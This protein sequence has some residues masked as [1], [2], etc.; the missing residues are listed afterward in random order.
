MKNSIYRLLFLILLLGCLF[1]ENVV[2]QSKYQYCL[3]VKQSFYSWGSCS[4]DPD[5]DYAEVTVKSSGDLY[6]KIDNNRIDLIIPLALELKGTSYYKSISNIVDSNNSNISVIKVH[7]NASDITNDHDLYYE[8][9]GSELH[10]GA[11]SISA[12]A[13]D[14]CNNYISNNRE[15]YTMTTTVYLD[16]PIN[17]F[18]YSGKNSYCLDTDILTL[19]TDDFF[20]NSFYMKGNNTFKLPYLEVAIDDS[21]KEEDAD[22]IEIKDVIIKPSTLI[23]LSYQRIAGEKSAN[24]RFFS[25]MGKRLKF[26][27]VK[28][29]LNG[30]RTYG[31]IAAGIIFYPK[32]PSFTIT[33]TRRTGCGDSKVIVKVRLDNDINDA[34][35]FN[36]DPDV[37]RWVVREKVAGTSGLGTGFY[38]CKPSGYNI[39]NNEFILELSNQEGVTV[40]PFSVSNVE[41]IQFEMQLQD[42]KNTSQYYCVKPFTI[43]PKPTPITITQNH[44]EWLV[45]NVIYDVPDRNNI[46]ANLNIQDNYILASERQPYRIVEKGGIEVLATVDNLNKSF[47]SLTPNEKHDDTVAFNLYFAEEVKKAKN[48]YLDY[49]K[50]KYK[51]WFD[52][53]KTLTIY[54]PS[55]EYYF[56]VYDYHTHGHTHTCEHAHYHTHTCVCIPEPT[57]IVSRNLES[58]KKIES[59]LEVRPIDCNN[60]VCSDHGVD[61][62]PENMCVSGHQHY[63]DSNPDFIEHDDDLHTHSGYHTHIHTHIGSH[64]HGENRFYD[65]TVIRKSTGVIL[66][67][68]YSVSKSLNSYYST[69]EFDNPAS[70]LFEPTSNAAEISD[71][72]VP[73]NNVD[74]NVEALA[75]FVD[76]SEIFNA[77][78]SKRLSTTGLNAEYILVK[79]GVETKVPIWNENDIMTNVYPAKGIAQP[80]YEEF[81]AFCFKKWLDNKYGYKLYNGVI[82]DTDQDFVLIDKDSC[83]YEFSTHV[84]VPPA[85]DFGKEIV[86]RPDNAC[87]RNGVVKV[88]YNGGG[89]PPYEY[90]GSY[91]RKA[92]DYILVSNLGY[93]ENI[94]RFNDGSI[95]GLNLVLSIEDSGTGII[96]VNRTPNTCPTP[97]GT[98]SVKTGMIPN[99]KTFRLKLRGSSDPAIAQIISND[100]FTF[101]DLKNGIYD[102]EV[103][104]GNNCVFRESNIVV[105]S[106]VFNIEKIT[107]TDATT[108]D[109]AGSVRIEFDNWDSN[110]NWVAPTPIGFDP[111]PS[112]ANVNYNGIIPNS[113]NITATHV[114]ESGKACNVSGQFIIR[115]P[116]FESEVVVEETNEGLFAKARLKSF[117]NFKLESKLQLY[118]DGSVVKVYDYFQ[119]LSSII[120]SN[121]DYKIVLKDGTDEAELCSFTY[122]LTGINNGYEVSPPRCPG[123]NGVIKLMPS[124]GIDG[125]NLLVSTDGSL[126]SKT[127]TYYPKSGGFEYY[128]KSEKTYD[129]Y[130]FG[131]LNKVRLS[132]IKKFAVDI[133]I[134]EK[135]NAGISAINVTCSGKNDGEIS[136]TKL[137]GGSGQYKFKVDDGLWNNATYTVT[138]LLPGLHK[139]YLKDS[140]NN[141]DSVYI[142][143]VTIKEPSPLVIERLDVVQPTCEFNNGSISAEIKGGNG[144]YKYIWLYNGDEFS[145]NDILTNDTIYDLGNTLRYGSYKLKIEDVYKCELEQDVNLVQY[146]NPSILSAKPVLVRC[147]GESNGE[148][149]V[150]STGGSYLIKEFYINEI[151]KAISDTIKSTAENFQNLKKGIYFITAVDVLGCYSNASDSYRIDITQPDT[152]VYLKLGQVQPVLNKGTRTGGIQATVFGG[153]DRLKEI[154]ITNSD[155]TW[156][157]T[158]Q[159]IEG[160]SFILDHLNAGKYS[161]L[162]TDSKGCSDTLN[163]IT[164]EEPQFP[165]NFKDV[166]VKNARCKAQTGSIEVQAEGGWGDYIFSGPSYGENF[167][168]GNRFENLYAGNYVITVK[169]KL[170]AT[171]SDTIAIYE[172]KDSLRSWVSGHVFPTCSNNG[173]IKLAFKGGTAPY[174]VFD[175]TNRF[176][177]SPVF[178][179]EFTVKG[180]NAN[181]YFM[182]ITDGNGCLYDLHT[183]LS[184]AQMLDVSF[185]DPVYPTSNS[186]TNGMICAVAKGGVNPL[187]YKWKQRFGSMYSETSSSLK[188][189]PS[190]HYEL[191]VAEKGGCSVTRTYYLPSIGDYPFAVAKIE[192]ETSFNKKNGYCKLTSQFKNWKEFEFITPTVIAHFNSGESNEQFSCVGD[193][194]LLKNLAGGTYFVSG[195]ADDTIKVYAEFT[196][197]PYIPFVLK[198]PVVENVKKIGDSNGR[199]SLTV[200][201]GGGGNTFEWKRTSAP[202]SDTLTAQNSPYGS[203]LSDIPAGSYEVTVIDRF[204]NIITQNVDVKE[205][206]MP[207]SVSIADHKDITCKTYNNGYVI[208]K[209]TGGW[210]GYQFKD[211][212]DVNYSNANQYVNLDP[213]NHKFYIIDKLGV[214]ES[215]A[216]S[217]TEPDYLNST[218]AFI[219]SV[220]CKGESTG[221]VKFHVTGGTPPYKFAYASNQNFW[222]NDTVARNV[223]YGE[224][225]YI[226]KDDNN[227]LT[228]NVIP[229]VKM[230]EPES[231]LFSK[232]DVTHTTCNIDNGKIEV[233]LKGGSKPYRYEWLN[234][235]NQNVGTASL[236]SQLSRNGFYKLNVYDRHDCYQG[237]DTII[238]P[239]SNPVVT[240]IDTTPVLCYGGSNGSALIKSVKAGDPYAPYTFEWSNGDSDTISKGY[241][242]GIYSVIVT[243]TNKCST[244]SYFEITQ[245][246]SLRISITD[247]KNAHCFD[248]ND[249]FL[250]AQGFGG[251]GTYTYQWSNGAVTNRIDKLYRGDYTLTLK[252]AN[253]CQ[254]IET[255]SVIEPDKLEVDLGEDIKMCPGNSRVVDGQEF[256]THKWSNSSGI[257]SNERYLTVRDANDYFL[258]V[259]DKDG[260]FAWDTINLSIGNDALKSEFLLSS[261]AE[262]GDTLSLVEL[263]NMEIDSLRWDYNHEAFTQVDNKTGLDYMFFLKTQKEGIYNVELSAFSGGCVSIS[264]KQIEIIADSGTNPNDGDLGYKDPLI[265]SFSVN[266]NP[267]DGNF[268]AEVKLRENSNITLILFSVASGTKINER[269]V[270]Q[271]SEYSIGYNLSNLNSGIYL[272]VLKAG[273]EMKQF[274]IIIQ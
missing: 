161:M 262:V 2:A 31:R 174:Q 200:E 142:G 137:S 56:T 249:A 210:G 253:G 160:I 178:D 148:I 180:L 101:T 224:Y 18:D 65:Y 169:D 37:Y 126:Y 138:G 132:I 146:H 157:S 183:E 1:E 248:Y 191:T 67:D 241:R 207:L 43:P 268:Y 123:E 17:L 99:P 176:R 90:E 111:S 108:L 110:V 150:F 229:L 97:N 199:I 115:K 173:E 30:E 147:Y 267:N 118:K 221:E 88:T 109:G 234:A 227:C 114:D 48:D 244:V 12:S 58:A 165:L 11:N 83:P 263:S 107:P 72:K 127:F 222:F 256:A 52:A 61:G 186:S 257:I 152:L 71:L 240:D 197:N 145:K 211:D 33:Q 113:Y 177:Y 64:A 116:H 80:W 143:S 135:V 212:V 245:P 205:P 247:R 103:D 179:K 269:Y 84:S 131:N 36:V 53:N 73:M 164:V 204:K 163:N 40:D 45:N 125:G 122:P 120:N 190:G 87:L 24:T 195:I 216:V 134:Q 8:F 255:F 238:K 85:I 14:P 228:Q 4:S 167:Y 236:L 252:D 86:K 117:E 162:A 27:V 261:Q 44:G 94:V 149:T 93:G 235:A 194:I 215:V 203:M 57:N 130:P 230:P 232:I 47:E 266:P 185:T 189:V 25:W 20:D 124:G 100:Y 9:N 66:D 218:V 59:V 208:L 112:S 196:I 270:T 63:E 265:K 193:T 38:Y 13:S 39:L 106:R 198:T 79:A 226:F 264:T 155:G 246:D 251:V 154:K 192:D 49:F 139:V 136:V 181:D 95:G 242:K 184:A 140:G 129:D 273:D 166:I 220:N 156:S 75:G 225:N 168:P 217:M 243:D 187:E 50:Y 22:W 258:E 54:H 69:T 78:D 5:Y 21:I 182:Q 104:A 29:L 214:V 144:L 60:Y 91:I 76:L 175:S 254:T 259:T 119:E 51:E 219:D 82:A 209:A 74:E 250:Q 239:S 223:P 128:I 102:L 213:R 41:P 35:Y 237:F 34:G 159:Q 271:Q 105:E 188:N 7:S 98:V 62:D 26:R 141:C 153:N 133:P 6:E 68:P 260:C 172:P 28:T 3:A 23:N 89:Y 77:I 171:F 231:L 32:G 201:G 233:E 16:D 81:K 70:N 121:G 206:S 42:S 55:N 46:Y 272:L 10:M 202:P 92:T 151:N 158:S 274:K 15:G 170:G 19:K 96:E